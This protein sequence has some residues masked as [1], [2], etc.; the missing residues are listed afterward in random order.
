[1]DPVL[2]GLPFLLPEK[3]PQGQR[4]PCSSRQIGI[5]NRD[6]H[7]QSTMRI[8][9]KGNRGRLTLPPFPRYEGTRTGIP[10][11]D[12]ATLNGLPS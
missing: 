10:S 5:G 12:R 11:L 7:Y 6:Y 4:A 3:L 9:P 8:R 1:M 2:A